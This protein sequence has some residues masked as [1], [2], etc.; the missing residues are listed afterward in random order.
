MDEVDGRPRGEQVQQ[1]G[2]E[3]LEI[4]GEVIGGAKRDGRG[5]DECQQDGANALAHGGLDGA[6]GVGNAEQRQGSAIE[7]ERSHGDQPEQG[8]QQQGLAGAREQRVGSRL[9]GRS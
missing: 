4:M 7:I 9:D 3:L 1:D 8:S 6:Q 2:E 5:A